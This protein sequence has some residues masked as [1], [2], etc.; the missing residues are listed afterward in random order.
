[1]AE[2]IIMALHPLTPIP[3]IAMEGVRQGQNVPTLDPK[4][5][6]MTKMLSLGKTS[7]ELFDRFKKELN[8][9][10]ST[11][12]LHRERIAESFRHLH[13]HLLKEKQARLVQNEDQKQKAI[14]DLQT[15]LSLLSNLSSSIDAMLFQ[16]EKGELVIEDTKQLSVLRTQFEELSKFKVAPHDYVSPFHTGDWRGIRHIVKPPKKALHFDPSSV[17]GN[18]V[19]SQNL[20]QVRFSAL[21]QPVK[22]KNCFE[23]GLYVLGVPGFESGQHYWEVDVGHKSNWIVGVVKDSVPRKEPQELVPGKGFWVLNKQHD[24]VYTACGLLSP[25]SKLSPLRIGVFLDFV[26]GYLAFYDPDTTELIFEITG[27]QFEGKL[28]PFCCPGVPVR[29]DDFGPLTLIN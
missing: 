19:L 28:F 6:D 23:P 9:V 20:K 16:Q 3:F 4:E 21:P 27:C 1:M 22:S 14:A 7:G 25:K 5:E 2:S 18:L 12:T 11:A 13:Q 10:H 26:G 8:E 17:N 15:K 24:D 29:E